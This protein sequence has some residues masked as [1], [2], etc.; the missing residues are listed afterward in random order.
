M[1][2][3]H[4]SLPGSVGDGIMVGSVPGRTVLGAKGKT[5]LEVITKVD[6]VTMT[7]TYIRCDHLPYMYLLCNQSKNSKRFIMDY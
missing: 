2:M 5:T 3:Y 7:P 1:Y 6:L 4:D